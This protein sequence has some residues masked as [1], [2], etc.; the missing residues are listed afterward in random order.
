MVLSIVGGELIGLPDIGYGLQRLPGR[1]ALVRWLMQRA[2]L[3]TGGPQAG[4]S[5]MT[6]P[7]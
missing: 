5:G 4:G 1:G 6:V 7:P 2:T 3:V